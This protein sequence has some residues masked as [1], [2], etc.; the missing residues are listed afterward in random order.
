MSPS[1]KHRHLARGRVLDA[2]GAAARVPR[3][4]RPRCRRRLPADGALGRLGSADAQVQAVPQ[5][6]Q[7]LRAV[8]RRQRRRRHG[9]RPRTSGSSN[10]GCS[11]SP[12]QVYAR[13]GTYNGANAILYA[14][15]M[16]KDAP[17]SG[18][19]HRHDWEGAVVWLSS[20]AADA[21]VVGVA[22][23]A[24]G[25]YDVKRAADVSFA[26]ARPKLGYRST[27]P[28]NHQ[29]VF[30]ADQG[31]EQPLV[32]WESLTP[33]ARAALQNTNFGSANVPFKDGNFASNLQKAAL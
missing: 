7:R 10:G 12:G 23:S 19:G 27:W 18:L 33:A 30:T 14:W 31:G 4:H 25:D 28:V 29:M 2:R 20:A 32:A 15:Y 26:G 9:R 6:V 1:L 8:S 13:A 3:R 11:S 22:A 21:T 24:H 16:P 5:G 17:S